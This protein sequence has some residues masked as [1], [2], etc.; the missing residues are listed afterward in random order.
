MSKKP[1]VEIQHN[2]R[3]APNFNELLAAESA[4][5]SAVFNDIQPWIASGPKACVGIGG[6]D[7]TCGRSARSL[8]RGGNGSIPVF[9]SK[10]GSDGI[11]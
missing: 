2:Q 5:R 3:L 11:I 1:G 6:P 10:I 9:Q 4:G 8:K 7:L